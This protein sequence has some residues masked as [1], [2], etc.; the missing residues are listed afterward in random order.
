[1]NDI[2]KRTRR[3]RCLH[4]GFRR[5]YPFFSRVLRLKGWEGVVYNRWMTGRFDGK[6]MLIT[7]D[8]FTMVVRPNHLTDLTAVFGRAEEHEVALII[9]KLK[10]GEIV[11]DAGAHIG[12][13]TLKAAKAV[14]P[15]GRV[16]AFEPDYENS[17]ILKQNCDINGFKWVEVESCALGAEDGY[18]DL[19]SGTDGATNTVFMNWHKVLHS[20]EDA[21]S[22]KKTKVPLNRLDNFLCIKKIDFVDLL[23]VDVEGAEMLLFKGAESLFRDLKIKAVICEVHSPIVTIDE[24]RAFFL[25]FRYSVRDIGGGEIYIN[26]PEGRR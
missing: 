25:P 4:N 12:R 14:G 11:I 2:E 18:I 8:G 16:I 20:E 21:K 17:D 22:A 15:E 5:W 6:M 10:P 23:K 9:D 19:F 1:M 26:S 13:Y 3:F 24:I 7:D